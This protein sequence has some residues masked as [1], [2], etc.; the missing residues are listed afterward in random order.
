M[1]PE[2]LS[3]MSSFT[4][5]C[6]GGFALF[7]LL[8]VG[9]WRARIARP[10]Y[11]ADQWVL[12]ALIAAAGVFSLSGRPPSGLE[13]FWVTLSLAI[14]SSLGWFTARKL[15]LSIENPNGV[16]M[17]KPSRVVMMLAV[18]VFLGVR[19]FLSAVAQT[20][21]LN[22]ALIQ[23]AFMALVLGFFVA[24]AIEISMRARTLLA[25]RGV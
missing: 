10:F 25:S 12:A 6:I 1:E 5:Y 21:H 24:R 20:D 11:P 9:F 18:L 4:V 2:M 23:N 15:E 17:A 16:I 22:P 14:G 19:F 3:D 7:A 13:W 8:A